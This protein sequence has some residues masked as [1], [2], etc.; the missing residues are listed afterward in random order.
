MPEGTLRR[1]L[2]IAEPSPFG[3]CR[4]CGRR[5][6]PDAAQ[7]EDWRAQVTQLYDAHRKQGTCKREDAS[8]A[9][10]RIVREATGQK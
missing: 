5:F 6:D 10:T 7:S 9:A 4:A 1:L 8:Q 2:V 3:V